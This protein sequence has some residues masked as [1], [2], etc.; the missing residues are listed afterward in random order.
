MKNSKR[1]LMSA[2]AMTGVV[3]I[4]SG[5][6]SAAAG[7]G[8][9]GGGSGDSVPLGADKEKWQAALA[10]ID[11]IDIVYQA[12]SSSTSS[13][14]GDIE[15]WAEMIEDYS[16]GNI[17][18]EIVWNYGIAGPTDSDEAL[19]D[20][21]VDMHPFAS[22]AS[23]SEFP[24]NG[25]LMLQASTYREPALVSGPLV[26]MG[27]L[28]EATWEVDGVV[29][30]W[31]DRGLHPIMPLSSNETFVLACKEPATTLA[32]LNG[33][34]IRTG[35]IG[36]VAQV[37][38]LGATSVTLPYTELY[39]ALQRGIVDC[40]ISAPG[41]FL[42]A[43]LLTVAPYLSTPVG[44]SFETS[45]VSDLAGANW[46][47]W[48]LAAQQL[49]FDSLNELAFKNIENSHRRLPEIVQEVEANGGSVQAFSDEVNSALKEHNETALAALAETDK[50]DGEEFVAMLD[51]QF[52]EWTA[53]VEE[54]GYSTDTL[55]DFDLETY[56][57]EVDLSAFLELYRER[58]VEP[59]RPH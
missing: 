29:E 41:V 45:T 43:G 33:K 32:D 21:R 44:A 56:E 40:L 48:P 58:V 13:G 20:G 24:I 9:A 27:A 15:A 5:C 11:P 22:F 34:L 18:V 54:A 1:M 59:N 42:E 25:D 51:E 8:G 38:A 31:T 14:A 19:V 26:A 39:E 52:A 35:T 53:L 28:N 6:A 3:A 50:L 36:Q 4:A 12:A 55:A 17:S 23:P 37:E 30:E 10:D 47:E 7:G 46:D 57:A 2:I 49:L 16:D